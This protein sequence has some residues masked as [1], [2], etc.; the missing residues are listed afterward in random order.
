MGEQEDPGGLK[1][2]ARKSVSVQ[3]R[4]PARWQCGL[5]NGECGV[6]ETRRGRGQWMALKCSCGSEVEAKRVIPVWLIV[7][8]FFCG[9][10]PGIVAL[11]GHNRLL[12]CADCGRIL[13]RF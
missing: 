9:I 11:Y 3:V 10:L 4:L 2:P 7:V 12:A 6:R 8:L 13:W 1:P 5:G